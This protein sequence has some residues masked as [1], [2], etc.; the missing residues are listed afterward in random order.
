VAFFQPTSWGETP[1]TP[2]GHSGPLKAQQG[3]GVRGRGL[4]SGI[5]KFAIRPVTVADR[6]A[7][8]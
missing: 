2:L 6:M 1:F 5:Y 4:K 3:M 8:G 7:I